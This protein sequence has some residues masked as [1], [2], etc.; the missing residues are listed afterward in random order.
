MDTD[1]KAQLWMEPGTARKR[2]RVSRGEYK[3][4]RYLDLR[5]Y[6]KDKDDGTYKPSK[7]GITLNK[8]RLLGLKQLFA[9]K[10]EQ[11][12]DWLAV[13]YVPDNVGKEKIRHGEAEEAARGV[14]GDVFGKVVR[15]VH[16]ERIFRVTSK[17]G[18]TEVEWNSGHAFTQEFNRLTELNSE[19]R[20]LVNKLVVFYS[21]SAEDCDANDDQTTFIAHEWATRLQTHLEKKA[22]AGG[23]ENA[24]DES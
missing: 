10:A 6:F 18:T 23:D 9:E 20:E 19:V 21:R 1:D 16:D 15:F 13:G 11:I 14:V 3:G 17:G 8:E 2:L 12:N 5:R 7:E 4:H 24:S 22:M